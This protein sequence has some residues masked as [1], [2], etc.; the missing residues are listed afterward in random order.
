M[1]LGVDCGMIKNVTYF[2]LQFGCE[3]WVN[4]KSESIPTNELYGMFTYYIKK[5]AITLLLGAWLVF[6]M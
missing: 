6:H 5:K 1:I 2:Y 3:L 4:A